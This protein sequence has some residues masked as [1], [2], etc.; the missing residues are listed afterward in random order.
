[1][2]VHFILP[3]HTQSIGAAGTSRAVTALGGATTTSCLSSSGA[4]TTV[5]SGSHEHTESASGSSCGGSG[6]CVRSGSDATSN[7]LDTYSAISSI[8]TTSCVSAKGSDTTSAIVT[9]IPSNTGNNDQ[10]VEYIL[11]VH[12]HSIGA[13]GTANAITSTSLNTGLT[14]VSTSSTSVASSS[15]THIE[16]ASGS[17]CGQGSCVSGNSTGGP[18]GTVSIV[19]SVNSSN[20]GN[21]ISTTTS[22]FINS[23]PSATGNN[24]QTVKS[25]LPRHTHT[26]SAPTT[27]S[28]GISVSSSYGSGTASLVAGG[29]A[30]S[31]GHTH[32]ESAGGSDCTTGGCVVSGSDLTGSGSGSITMYNAVN[33]STLLSSYSL[34]TGT[35]VSAIP[36][37]TGA[38]VTP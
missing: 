19:T 9:S 11:S 22:S 32:S 4:G 13:A 3:S 10:T 36:S 38:N 16:T 14:G 21:D 2:T 1:M 18:S 7:S 25:I 5:T 33:G 31:S 6:N 37:N 35:F 12:T 26:I 28:V 17:A 24:D 20:L 8:F 23:I 29:S 34:T 30:G 15:H 27:R